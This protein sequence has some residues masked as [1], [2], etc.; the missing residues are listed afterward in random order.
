M[1]TS[2]IIW[3]IIH[4]VCA[5][6]FVAATT[7]YIDAADGNDL[8]DGTTSLTAWQS[9]DK[10]NQFPFEP[11]DSILFK[12][13]SKWNGMLEVTQSGTSGQPIVFSAYG[14]GDKPLIQG[15][16]EVQAAIFI[17]NSASY[18]TVSGL[19]VTNYDSLDIYD[20]GEG[21][22]S[23]IHVGEWL[24]E[25]TSIYLLDNEIYFIE[26]CSN[27]GAVGPPRGTTLDPDY[28]NHYQNAGI[29]VHAA[30]IDTLVIDGNY[31]H[32][33]T[34]TG[35]FP[36]LFE[37]VTNLLIQHNSVYNVG[38]DGIVILHAKSPLV[39]LNAVIDAGNNS[40][41]LPRAP[42]QL[43][44]N[45][46]A[47]AGIW[48]SICSDPVFQYNY[49]E[50][51]K[52]IVWDGQAWDFD[53]ET[54]GKAIYQYNFS[55]D[56]E[57]G[58]NLGGETHQLFRYNVS[59]N[60]GAKQG[61]AQ[62]FF[63]G[64]PTYYNNTFYRDDM[65]GFLMNDWEKQTFINNIFYTNSGLEQ[66]YQSDSS[67]FS[68]NAYFGHISLSPGAFPVYGDPLL[69]NPS[70]AGKILPGVKFTIT[71]LRN[72][73]TGFM[74]SEGSACADVG[75]EIM[76]N[77]SM[78]L[79]GNPLYYNGADIG[80]H[81]LIE[82][83]ALGDQHK[84]SRDPLLIYPNPASDV[85]VLSEATGAYSNYSIYTL[86]GQFVQSGQNHELQPTIDISTLPEGGYIILFMHKDMPPQRGMF[87]KIH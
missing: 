75:Q 35:I 4:I 54:T 71:D 57:G 25:M 32:D 11:G 76:D 38:G 6:A 27:H 59:Y 69:L 73:V 29:F 7:Y 30:Y 23:G 56:N 55:R 81:E 36:F 86:A 12:R 67:A 3:I 78:D 61:N 60:D 8:W 49:C 40:G 85:L 39:Q 62:Y 28:Y 82:P 10:V 70:Q 5:P 44:F 14:V 47:V 64:S 65:E 63:N 77:G 21:L 33:C 31:V 50:G 48:S 68:H 34:C 42:G 46:L 87:V 80:A 83:S 18:I 19:A 84:L 72:A 17:R 24:G 45:G 53:L 58:F 22:R 41:T 16:G 79:W 9:L 26:G 37:E 43:G 51:T 20:G 52:R 1:K 74:I 66:T 13:G 15:A 2:L